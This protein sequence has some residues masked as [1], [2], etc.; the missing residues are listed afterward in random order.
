MALLLAVSALACWNPS[1]E[2]LLA[3]QMLDEQIKM[4]VPPGTEVIVYDHFAKW[5]QSSAVT[6][7]STTLPDQQIERFYE[8]ELPKRG[9]NQIPALPLTAACFCRKGWLAELG[10]SPRRGGASEYTLSFSR[11]NGFP[12]SP[13]HSS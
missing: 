11:K 4:A 6:R 13:C 12:R 7:F 3:R 10:L 8:Q 2:E 5:T 9:W 1:D